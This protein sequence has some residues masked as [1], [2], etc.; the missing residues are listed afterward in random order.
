MEIVSQDHLVRVAP[1]KRASSRIGCTGHFDSGPHAITPGWSANRKYPFHPSDGPPTAIL[2][3]HWA[4]PAPA[5]IVRRSGRSRAVKIAEDPPLQVLEEVGD[6]LAGLFG[7]VDGDVLALFG[8]DDGIAAHGLAGVHGALVV[9]HRVFDEPL[10]GMGGLFCACSS[11]TDDD[12]PAFL[13]GE[14]G[15]IGGIL[16]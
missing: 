12:V 3:L 8:A 4:S 5:T 16:Q 9:V 1:D 2:P 6:F 7:V 13:A 15:S 10:H 11:S 14:V